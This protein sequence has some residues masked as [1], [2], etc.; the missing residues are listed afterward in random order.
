MTFL[1]SLTEHQYLRGRLQAE[2]PEADEQTLRDTIEGISSLPEAL[3]ALIRSY[4]EDL[5]LSAALGMRIENMQER[6]KRI[7]LRAD[8][9][10]DLVT[11]V[12][13]QA[14]IKKLAEP[15][16]TASLRVVPPSVVVVDEQQIPLDFWKVQSPKLDKQGLSL[17]LRAGVP[18]PGA[19]LSNSGITL[20]VRTK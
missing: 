20:S 12:M 9:K 3:A 10:R 6:L 17:A 16:F 8:K 11:S 2:F 13:E 19:I 15:D 7:E 5:S 18:V 4:L 1:H 14:D